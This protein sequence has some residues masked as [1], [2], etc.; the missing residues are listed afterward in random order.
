VTRS[1]T[2]ALCLMLAACGKNADQ[3]REMSADEVARQMAAVKVDP[4]QWRSTTEIVSAKGPLPSEALNA[5]VGQ[6]TA[7]SHCI[8]PEEAAR[9]SANFLAAQQGSDCSYQ[10]FRM[11]GGKV[12]GR[13]TCTGGAFGGRV[14]TAMKGDYG[15]RGYD[16]VMDMETPSLPGGAIMRIR[17]RTHGQRVGDCT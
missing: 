9:P 15:P 8:T 4:G 3:G 6:R 17:A 10:D 13:M 16:M 14:V 12:S 11:A 7:V 2:I 1:L 5:M